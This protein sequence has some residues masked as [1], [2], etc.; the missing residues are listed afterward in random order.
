M[1]ELEHSTREPS[2]ST[3]NKALPRTIGM[4][5]YILHALLGIAYNCRIVVDRCATIG[6]MPLRWLE[7][8]SDASA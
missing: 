6:P 8:G 4:F 5:I 7:L 1:G 3:W 2:L